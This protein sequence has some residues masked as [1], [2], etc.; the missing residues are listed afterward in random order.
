MI[1]YLNSIK[2]ISIIYKIQSNNHK[3][4]IILKLIIIIL[5]LIIIS[6]VA[7]NIIVMMNKLF[8]KSILLAKINLIPAEIINKNKH[9]HKI[10]KQTNKLKNKNNQIIIKTIISRQKKQKITNRLQ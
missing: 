10:T 3:I 9:K 6:E 2:I 4:T 5:K 1:Y 8:L 7:N